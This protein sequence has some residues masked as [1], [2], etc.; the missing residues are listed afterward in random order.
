MQYRVANGCAIRERLPNMDAYAIKLAT[1]VE[2]LVLFFVP[3]LKF[4]D[5]GVI[6]ELT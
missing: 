3:N 2:K 1:D 6:P 4:V 5:A